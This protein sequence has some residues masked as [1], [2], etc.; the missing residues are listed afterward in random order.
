MTVPDLIYAG[1]ARQGGF[2]S[3]QLPGP[4]V[5]KPPPSIILRPDQ[6]E[7]APAFAIGGELI[8]A[9]IQEDPPPPAGTGPDVDLQI[10]NTSPPYGAVDCLELAGAGGDFPRTVRLILQDQR[11]SMAGRQP[12]TVELWLRLNSSTGSESASVSVTISNG[13]QPVNN[14]GA[15]GIQMGMSRGPDF[16]ISGFPTTS[17]VGGIDTAAGGAA[18]NTVDLC[19][20]SDFAGAES[21]CGR[22]APAYGNA[23]QHHAMS[24]DGA[25]LRYFV[26][27]QV[28]QSVQREYDMPDAEDWTMVVR[29]FTQQTN[30]VLLRAA[31]FPAAALYASN[32][33]PP[34][35]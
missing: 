32:F 8:A 31:R 13:G 15:V 18:P 21:L 17:R 30:S 4:V 25:T 33:T 9:T 24:F 16:S 26:G 7:G 35:L 10:T 14:L 6:I 2:T 19:I 34:Q 3:L 28:L 22:F 23:W 5:Y 27:G 11:L 20:P 12:Y 1:Q 29:M